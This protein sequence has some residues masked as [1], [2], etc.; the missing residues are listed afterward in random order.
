M[1]AIKRSINSTQAPQAVGAY[2]QAIESGGLVF[3]SGQI[4]LDPASG[5]LIGEDTVSQARQVMENLKGIV[6][7]AGGDWSHLVKVTIYLV[8][9]A[10]FQAVDALYSSY[11]SPPYPARATVGVA[12][13]PKGARIEIDA[14]AHLGR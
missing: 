13:L 8:D 12:A 4:A 14:I 3:I 6:T 7:A 9:L 1:T 5:L 2:S 11:L 10:D